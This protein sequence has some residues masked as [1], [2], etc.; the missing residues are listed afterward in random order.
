MIEQQLSVLR[1]R[2]T[3]LLPFVLLVVLGLSWGLY[4]PILKF[5]ARSGLPYSGI[6]AA[7]ICGV[8][9]ALLV[10][11]LARGLPLPSNIEETLAGSDQHVI[12][13]DSALLI[14]PPASA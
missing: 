10:V 5:A 6:A 11:S 8:A 13:H 9:L 12:A 3:A 2:C 7:A 4:F 14:Q 1:T